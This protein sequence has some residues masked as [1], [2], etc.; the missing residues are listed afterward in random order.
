MSILTDAEFEE[1]SRS[2]SKIWCVFS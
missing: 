2:S 1:F